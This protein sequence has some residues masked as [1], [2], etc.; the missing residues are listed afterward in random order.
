MSGEEFLAALEERCL[1]GNCAN[2][3]CSH[4]LRPVEHKGSFRIDSKEQKVYAAAEGPSYCDSDCAMAAQSFAHRLGSAG[5]A[6]HRFEY[7][8]EQL[9]EKKHK[10]RLAA[11]LNAAENSP[12]A[13]ESTSNGEKESTPSTQ[14]TETT[15]SKQGSAVESSPKPKGVLKK[16]SELA[17]GTKKVPIMSAEVKE[18]DPGSNAEPPKPPSSSQKAHAIEGYVPR[19]ALKQQYSA[20]EEGKEKRRVHFSESLEMGPT[21]SSSV[22]AAPPTPITEETSGDSSEKEASNNFLRSKQDLEESKKGSCEI[23]PKGY[24]WEEEA[25]E[26]LKAQKAREQTGDQSEESITTNQP[27]AEGDEEKC[28]EIFK[29]EPVPQAGAQP[30][31]Q[32]DH[33]PMHQSVIERSVVQPAVFV[34]DVED[35]EGPIEVTEHSLSSK[36]GR[37]RVA[38]AEELEQAGLPVPEGIDEISQRSR[39]AVAVNSPAVRNGSNSSLSNE[40]GEAREGVHQESNQN[41]SGNAS[42]SAAA[43][44]D[45]SA[46]SSEVLPKATGPDG[47]SVEEI[48]TERLRQGASKYFPQLAS[49]FPPDLMQSLEESL[50]D[51]E[52]SEVSESESWML[53]DDDLDDDNIRVESRH[54]ATF[55]G[56]LITNFDYWVTGETINLFQS[57]P[58]DPAPPSNSDSVAEIQAA[59]G[60]FLSFALAPLFEQ[61]AIGLPRSEVERG[62][63]DVVRTLCLVRAL[64]AFKSSQWQLVAIIFLKAL[65]MER[66]P[67]L[68]P[69]FETREGVRRVNKALTANSFTIEEF[70]A[71]LE[72]LLEETP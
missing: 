32:Q 16:K 14:D 39:G 25:F 47:R 9:Q 30:P 51:G 20:S 63:M 27:H 59:L 35:A 15:S 26:Q 34:L 6:M 68:R 46:P 44:S 7:L 48:L 13:V 64:P 38:N 66:L 1:A 12:Q 23:S 53:S 18:R 3:L 19:A 58:E 17:A 11:Q 45:T 41:G 62:L 49:T 22:V 72:V 8:M 55:F 40:D 56:E 28:L 36:F 4:T 43:I 57:S 37:L 42:A 33:E 61:L 65:S 54:K 67:G 5:Q 50:S 70:A 24:G 71:V 52:S 21:G 2:A 29:N 31:Q 10:Q 60:R 69:A